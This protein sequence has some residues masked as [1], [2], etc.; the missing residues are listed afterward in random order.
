MRQRVIEI[1]L[2]V[3]FVAK[4]TR[5]LSLAVGLGLVLR[6]HVQYLVHALYPVDVA[7]ALFVVT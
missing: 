3:S 2:T 4:L 6:S 5:Y 7:N 1:L